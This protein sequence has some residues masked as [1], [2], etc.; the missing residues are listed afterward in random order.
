MSKIDF[1][2]AETTIRGVFDNYTISAEISNVVSAPLWTP[3]IP[4]V[5]N[6]L[7]PTKFAICIVAATVVDPFNFFARTY[8]RS[9]II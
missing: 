6:T 8:P 3:P 2:P 4:P 5:T 1:I 9:L 7:I